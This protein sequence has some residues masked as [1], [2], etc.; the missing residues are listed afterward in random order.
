MREAR[1]AP[2]EA[3][4]DPTSRK[5]AGIYTYSDEGRILTEILAGLAL[6]I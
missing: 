1:T 2:L 3:R 6:G 5:I 4:K